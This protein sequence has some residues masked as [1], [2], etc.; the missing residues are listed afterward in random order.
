MN[1]CTDESVGLKA[2][3]AI[4][5]RNRGPALG[6]CR[7]W[8]YKNDQAA[9][10]DVLRLSR[11]MTYK[12]AA[13]KV[14]LGGG[15]S[16]IIGDPHK[17]K[18]PAMMQAMGRWIES[19]G[20][21]YIVGEDIGTN[22]LDMAEIGHATRH[23]TCRRVE[24]GGYGDPAPMTALGVFSALRAGAKIGLDRA[25]LEG[26]HVAVQGVGNVGFNL[27][28]LLHDA[29]AKLTVTDVHRPNLDRAVE[30][31][32]CATVEP[33]EILSLR[34]DILSP[35]AMGAVL[36]SETIP[37]LRAKVIAGA[38]NNQLATD[39]DGLAL[40]ERGV[41]YLPDYVANGGGLISCEAEYHGHPREAVKTKVEGIFDTA[42]EILER[43][44]S[45]GIATSEAADRIAEERFKG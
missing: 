9:I 1:A 35:C 11:G 36:N 33:D 19:L 32:G 27:C 8:P 37:G 21:D 23:V 4:H 29:G 39:A 45:E 7:M 42:I 25:D 30:A 28:R 17:Q 16:V 14:A 43:A 15:K 26:L 44:D 6:G 10:D 3:I 40:K 38:A 18:T 2:I 24:D 41:I 22:P 12:A 34:A 31:F 20:G 13:M 5:N